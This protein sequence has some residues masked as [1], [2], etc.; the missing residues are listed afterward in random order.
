[1]N[2]PL[3]FAQDRIRMMLKI[4]DSRR[5]TGPN[6]L[7]DRPG[8]ILEVTVSG[9]PVER[10]IATW[11]AHARRLLDAVGWNAEAKYTRPF[12]GGANLALSAP[13]D[14][15]YA[16]T[17]VNEAA[18][19]ATVAEITGEAVEDTGDVV[20]RLNTYIADEQNPALLHL[21]DAAKKHGVS[22][23]SDDDF[24]SIGLG[25]GATIWPVDALPNPA[26]VDWNAVHDIPV[27]LITGTNGKSTTVRL[28][29]S[30]VKADGKAAGLT[31]TDFIR[32]GDEI[33]DHGDY[34]GPGGARTLLRNHQ[35]EVGLLEV[36]RG[37][38][39]RRGLALPRADAALIT[40]VAEDHLGEYGIN[41]L[42]E[43]ANAKFVVNRALTQGGV[44]V[45]NA[46]DAGIVKQ[47][48]HVSTT[49]CWFSLDAE[50]PVLRSHLAAGGRAC[51]V[52]E[53]EI[54]YASAAGEESII[55]VE[56]IPITLHGAAQHNMSNSLGAVGLAKALQISTSAIVGGLR[57]F[58]GDPTD[59]P[60]RGNYFDIKGARVLVD[61]AH[62]V[63]GLSAIVNTVSRMPAKRRLVTL[64][65]AG[66]RS[67]E[68]IRSLVQAAWQSHPDQ[69]VITALPG[70]ERGRPEGE[71]PALIH[72]E[73]NRLGASDAGIHHAPS[74]LDGVKAA[75]EWAEE[76]DLLLLLVLTQ[77][78]EVFH[79][80]QEAH[81]SE[82]A[83]V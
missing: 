61:F 14:A 38:L 31:S 46:D 37:G 20:A 42:P 68:D 22:F 11:T 71:V 28:L 9:Y 44:L 32:V 75:I 48:K 70:Y 6:L 77:R 54:V 1:M 55:A 35:V 40:N 60:G 24:V 79:F 73:L 53:G 29:S 4:E 69:V 23:L 25:K 27:A 16:A 8:A 5:L 56:D 83:S 50:N 51:F 3:H 49:L 13:I 65:Q 63:H 36:A 80:L 26:D 66:D 33:L 34:S 18:W 15:L 45:L 59:N 64:G 57:A 52:R 43:L 17:E 7:S 58:R 19:D 67:D 39:L 62:N 2:T 78:E 81:A 47:A 21:R 72:T 41:T 12:E 74:C 76:G 30:I 82:Q 10:V